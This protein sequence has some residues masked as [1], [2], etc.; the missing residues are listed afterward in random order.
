MRLIVLLAAAAGSVMWVG[1]A[2]A[3][4]TLEWWQFWT[5][6]DI[7]PTVM[8]IVREFEAKNP[9]IKV[10][11]TDLTWAQ[12][13]EKLVIAF[14]ANSGPDVLE[15]GSDWIAQ[16]AANNQLADLSG[17]IKGDS[18]G[19]DGWGLATYGGKVYGRP[20]ILGTR[21]LFINRDVL[22]KG[23]YERTYI[24]A[25][26][27]QLGESAIK[28][29]QNGKGKFFGWGSNAPEKHRLYKKY[30]PFFWSNGAQL[31]T[32]DGKYCVISSGKAIDALRLYQQ[33]NDNGFVADQR[34][35]EDAW[36]EGKIAYIISGDWLI[37]R[38]ELEKRAVDYGT[39][40]IPGPK[41]P[42]KSFMGGE[43]LSI[44]AKSAHQDEARKFIA[45]MTSPENQVRFCKANR[46]ANP[47]SRTAQ[48]DPYFQNNI[49]LLTFIRQLTQSEHPPVDPDWPFMEDAIEKAVEDALFG[50]KLPATALRNAQIK[51]TQLKRK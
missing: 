37:K 31:F 42:G 26:W 50:S 18:A 11:V 34:G 12:G 20:W 41:Y 32:D 14:A 47:S 43:F 22:A 10:N 29:S 21:V 25:N 48:A 28:I 17:D 4:T 8:E 13:Q 49:N 30:M 24:P 38:I 7:K 15:L 5:D 36:L 40:F 33:L 1:S 35:I 51:I 44:N 16:F 19:Y 39:T 6:P 27:P 2:C 3:E 9:D 23:G 46:S 45:W